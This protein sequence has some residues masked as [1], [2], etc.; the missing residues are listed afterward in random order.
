M[1]RCRI[2][3]V[4]ANRCRILRIVYA[5]I[6]LSIVSLITREHGSWGRQLASSL[7]IATKQ[8]RTPGWYPLSSLQMTAARIAGGARAMLQSEDDSKTLASITT[9]CSASKRIFP[10]QGRTK[11]GV[12]DFG[13]GQFR[14]L[15]MRQRTPP[16]SSTARCCIRFLSQLNRGVPRPLAFC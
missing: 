7:A 2:C 11:R 1:W 3:D 6:S 5:H 16:M 10:N 9:G 13:C 4:K 14:I 12:S 8:C 15:I